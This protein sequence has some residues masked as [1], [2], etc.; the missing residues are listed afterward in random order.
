MKPILAS[1]G[2]LDPARPG[3]Q[4]VFEPEKYKAFKRK[5]RGAGSARRG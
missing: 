4:A 3:R 2:A 1:G 5:E